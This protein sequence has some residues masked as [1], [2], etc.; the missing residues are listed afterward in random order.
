LLWSNDSR[1]AIC[2]DHSMKPPRPVIEILKIADYWRVMQ[3]RK[4]IT[5]RRT[6]ADAQKAARLLRKS[7]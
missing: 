7:S 1:A 6:K 5:T 3:D 2:Y 4:L